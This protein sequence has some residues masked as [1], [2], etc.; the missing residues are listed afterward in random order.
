MAF[1]SKPRPNS[2]SAFANL[3]SETLLRRLEPRIMFD[4]A[5]L[6]TAMDALHAD[7]AHVDVADAA[8]ADLLL[9]LAS[10]S[11]LHGSDLVGLVDHLDGPVAVQSLPN[12]R[13]VVFIDANVPDLAVL[14]AAI[15]DTSEIVVL[16]L[17]KDGLDQMASY[18]ADRHDLDAIH[19]ISHGEPGKLHLGSSTY[20][21]ATL[22]AFDAELGRIGAALHQ[23]GDILIYGCDVAK[24]AEGDAFLHKFADLTHA[25]VAGSTDLTGAA[26]FGGNWVLE[27]K[28]GIIEATAIAAADWTGE[29]N[30]V[31]SVAA[32]NTAVSSIF[33]TQFVGPGITATAQTQIGAAEQFGTFTND[34]TGLGLSK[35]PLSSGIVMVTG[36]ASSAATAAGN[37]SDHQIFDGGVSTTVNAG[38]TSASDADLNA[39]SGNAGIYDAAGFSFKFKSATDR[40]GF[41][42]SFASEEYP[43]FVGTIYNDAFGFFIQGGTDYATKT[44]L[45][46]V[47]GTSEGIAVNT[48]NPGV[49]GS[50]APFAPLATIDA[51]NTGLYI[52]NS[53]YSGDHTVGPY[54]EYDGL[55]KLLTVTAHVTRDT[56]YTMKIAIGDAGDGSYDSA[57]FFKPQGFL[58]LASATA[59]S[60]TGDL[61]HAVSGNVVSDDTGKGVDI[62]PT[63]GGITGITVTQVNGAAFGASPV[64]LASG[65]KVTMHADGSFDY[66]PSTNTAAQALSAGA[67]LNDSFTYSIVDSTGVTDTATVTVKITNPDHAPV[68]VNDTFSTSAGA[69]ITIH[70]LGN[71]SDIDA[72]DTLTVTKVAGQ[73][74]VAG[75]VAI[76]VTGGK[77]TLDSNNDLTFTPNAGYLGSPSFTY[78]INDGHG[79]SA[80]AT[81]GGTVIAAPLTAAADSFT[82]PH[83][84]SILL[85]PLANDTNPSGFAFAITK[86]DGGSITAGGP[87]VTVSG[88]TVAL[89]LT[90]HL[91]FKPTPGYIGTPSF[92]YTIKDLINGASSTATISGAVT[93]AQPLIDLGG[94]TLPSASNL[95]F[96]GGIESGA[97]GW[98]NTSILGLPVPLSYLSGINSPLTSGPAPASSL[99]A[100]NVLTGIAGTI[101]NGHVLLQNTTAVTLTQGQLYNFAFDVKTLVDIQPL[102]P[103]FNWVVLDASNNV[104]MAVPGTFTTGGTGGDLTVTSLAWNT[105]QTLQSSFVSTLATGTYKIGMTWAPALGTVGQTLALD[106]DRIYLGA[107][108]T[109]NVTTFTEDGPAVAIVAGAAQIFDADNATMASAT[110]VLTNKLA[111][112][113]L[114]IGGTAVASGSTGSINGIAYSVLDS[115]GQETIQLT[116]QA[117]KA[118]YAAALHAIAFS[119]STVTPAATDRILN[120]SVNDGM[121]DSAVGVST[122]HVIALPVTAAD[123]G[124][125]IVHSPVTVAVLANDTDAGGTLD[126]ASVKIAGTASAGASLL[127]AGEGTW[128]VNTTSGAITFTPLAAFSSAPTPISYT[129]ADVSGAVSNLASVSIMALHAA[130]HIDLSGQS[131]KDG[132]FTYPHN[133]GYGANP[134][135]ASPVG[136]TTFASVSPETAGPGL[137]L[138]NDGSSGHITQVSS[139]SLATSIAQ[140]EYI[141]MS[142]ATLTTMPETWLQETALRFASGQFQFAMAISSDGFKSA[143]LL[144]TD[145][146]ANTYVGPYYDSNTNYSLTPA[147]DFKLQPGT[148]YELRAYIFN[149]P[150]GAAAQ[151]TWDDFY[152]LYSSDPTGYETTFNAG[153]SPVSISAPAIELEDSNTANMVSASIVLANKQTSDHFAIGGVHTVN[154]STGTIGGINYAVTES[155]GTI[156]VALSGSA[157]EAQ[158]AAFINGVAFENTSSTPAIVDRTINVTVS[159]GVETSNVATTIVHVNVAPEIAVSLGSTSGLDGNSVSIQTKGAFSDANG[160]ALTY[161]AAGLPS[162]LAIDPATGKISGTLP[163]DAS[164]GGIA[165]DGVFAIA[166]TATDP[167]GLAVTNTL[168]FSAN[169]IAPVAS[170][171]AA[172][173]F[174]DAAVTFD[175]LGNDHDGSLDADPLAVSAIDG[176]AIVAGGTAIAV[177][178]GSVLLGLDDKLTFTPDADFNGSASFG[179][180]V[181][182]GQGGTAKAVV[183][184]TVASVNDA[185]AGADSAVST[186]EDADYILSAPD[187]GFTDPSDSPASTFAAVKIATLPGSGALTLNGQAVAQGQTVPLA[188]ITAG[189]LVWTPAADANGAGL[190]SLTFQVQDNGGALNGGLDTDASPN[191]LTFDVTP[192]NDPPVLNLDPDNSQGGADNG[193][194]NASHAVGSA[195]VPI[196]D[197]DV[198]ISDMDSAA[199][200]SLTIGVSGVADG[201]AEHLYVGGASGVDIA[202]DGATVQSGTVTVGGTT[203]LVCFDPLGGTKGIVVTN[204][205]GGAISIA[206]TQALI[207]A[208]T[209]QDTSA[210]STEGPRQIVLTVNDGVDVSSSVAAIID[211]HGGVT[212]PEDTA[213]PLGLNP[214]DFAAVISG[215]VTIQGVPAG[216]TLSSSTL[217]ADGSWTAPVADLASITLTPP[218]DYTGNFSID[219]CGDATGSGG[220]VVITTT[221]SKMAH[222]VTATEVCRTLDIVVIPTPD[223][224]EDPIA[225]NED[226]QA[227]AVN[228]L[229]NDDLGAGTDG[230]D[231][232]TI[233]TAPPA[234]QGVLTFVQDGTGKLTTVA[235]GATLSATE[236]LTLTFKPYLNYNGTVTIP[237]I[238]TDVNGATSGANII[239][240]VQAVD[241]P[242]QVVNPNDPHTN[243]QDPSYGPADPNAPGY[244]PQNPTGVPDPLNLI[245]DV[246]ST[247]GATPASIPA[248]SYFGDAEGDTLTFSATGLPPG[249]SINSTTGLIDGT[250]DSNASQSNTPGDPVGVYTVVVTATDPS[251]HA[252]STT[253]TYT[254]GNLPPVATADTADVSE[255]G[256]AIAGNALANDHDTAL[257][258][259]ALYVAS[260]N[261]DVSLI[262][263]PVAGSTGGSF[264]LKAD[265]TWTFDAGH[266]FDNLAAGQ[267]R[268]T[269]ITYRVAD[270]QGGHA[271]ATVTVTVTGV[272]DAPVALGPIAPVLAVDAGPVTPIDASVAFDNPGNL[273]L[274]YS[275]SNL[276]AGLSIDPATGLITG[277][278]AHGAS[279]QGPYVVM[280]TASGPSGETS[281]TALQINVANPAPVAVA[282][283]ATT[284]A[285]T[286]VT[287]A[288]LANDADADGDTLHVSSI[289]APANGMATLNPDGTITY[290]PNAG[291]VG[292]E[293]ISYT[294]TDAQGGT[295]TA[296]ITIVVGVAPVDAPVATSPIPD[297]PD[298]DGSPIA[299]VDISAFFADPNGQPLAFSATGLPMGL[300]IDPVTGVISGAPASDASV[301]GPYSVVVTAV[302]PDGNQVS[303]TVLFALANPA[304]VAMIDYSATPLDMPVTIH[305]LAN[306]SDPDGDGL[307]VVAV[308]QP[309][310]GTVVINAD[311]TLT[312]TPNA[313]FSGVE[314]FTYTVSDGQRGTSVADAVVAVDYWQPIQPVV[315]GSVPT[316]GSGLDG[317]PIAPIDV[318]SHVTDLFGAPLTFTAAGLPAGLAI[319]ATTGVITG[320]LGANASADGP[321]TVTVIAVDGYGVQVTIPVVITAANPA[322]AAADDVASTAVNQPV[323]IG[324]LA[325]DADP[326][327]DVLTVTATSTPAHGTVAI[328]PNGAV[329]FTP[330]AGFTGT[331]T[332]TYSVT[333]ANGASKTATVTV[334]IGNP[335]SLAAAPGIAAVSGVDGAPIT[336]VSVTAAFGDPDKS[337]LLK[338]SVEETALPPGITFSPLTG[339]FSGT[340]ANNASQGNTLGQPIGTYLVPVTAKDSSSASATTYVTFMFTNQP[341]VA[342]DDKPTVSEDGP[343]LTGNVLGND[344]DTAPDSDPLTV[345]GAAQGANTITLGAP[346][347]TAGGGVLTLKADG[348]YAFNPGTAYNGLPVN[349]TATETI[350]YTV[351]DGNGGATMAKLVITI[352]G[353]N[354]APLIVDPSTG[355]PIGAGQPVIPMQHGVDGEPIQPVAAAGFFR[356]PDAGDVLTY[357]VVNLPKGLHFDPAT[358]LISGVLNTHASVGGPFT[359]EVTATDNHGGNSTATFVWA[360][361]NP[362]PVAVGEI[363][364]TTNG[365]ALHSSVAG[366]DVDPDT[367]GISY[368]VE[369]G[370][371]HG[372]L[373]LHPDGTY[374]YVADSQFSGPDS[375]TY[376]VVDADGGVAYAVCKITVDPA[377]NIAQQTG[378][379]AGHNGGHAEHPIDAPVHPDADDVHEYVLT[380][381]RADGTETLS[382][383]GAEHIRLVVEGRVQQLDQAYGASKRD[384]PLH[385]N[386]GLGRDGGQSGGT[387]YE[388]LGDA[389]FWNGL[390]P[391]DFSGLAVREA[392]V[393][394]ADAPF[395]AAADADHAVPFGDRLAQ[396]RGRFDREALRLMADLENAA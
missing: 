166:V 49:P 141:S 60:Y 177:S 66:D 229:A 221:L 308:T 330:H 347:I 132:A 206:D 267:S 334:N 328:N 247:D 169:N 113:Q 329:T 374:T 76:T 92:T 258:G 218:K 57:V 393:G 367:D 209:Y 124:A 266:A 30:T 366:N 200:A 289:D 25:D 117:N 104:A 88:G 28:T 81:V 369:T 320:A 207:A 365:V 250:L 368:R 220:G 385:W 171:D 362:L 192:V 86:I 34:A 202:L 392:D 350:T 285:D 345:V 21:A 185:P 68:A 118:S 346:F 20:D 261:G 27:D 383:G 193:G 274:V 353:A 38:H 307:A 1:D 122:V 291:F 387:V 372:V 298:T 306:D 16:D 314:Y 148:N 322:P 133:G 332:F 318:G 340:P 3:M 235:D 164:V 130:P 51:N 41:V 12:A 79:G 33:Q 54:L 305:V 121:L 230:V 189:K 67:T 244:D 284:P 102:A 52:S 253:V 142:F 181:A 5:A 105:W 325:N 175:V 282:D 180:T 279:V 61:T 326:D 112:D 95:L 388:P 356:D 277:T 292:T 114:S 254:I 96:N 11:A 295:S 278:P 127:V 90:G 255:D 240:T 154:G 134:S 269:V 156:S 203:F 343:K 373:T 271:I 155:A 378:G 337:G 270:G 9:D 256:P 260:V 172:S 225:M 13:T 315:D 116:G 213:I 336:P 8:P 58:A 376:A 341:P 182:D 23:G 19:I 299:P 272:N 146:T 39:L 215:E 211:V 4:A 176:H 77:V 31:I 290:V 24:G 243:P 382:D 109:R 246:A 259:D 354:D 135:W 14:E 331:D 338:L 178:H 201:A 359:V 97:S 126:P 191:T 323:V 162:W 184:V 55:T 395:V 82:T 311:G 381:A 7:P 309:A 375:F 35:I 158:Y 257:D 242:V 140:G 42:F 22:K 335:G 72:G 342:L 212:G 396:I 188:D 310:N 145:K 47:P 131:P 300:I 139:T 339:T 187:F 317:S 333:D 46:V 380:A 223:A 144:S 237:Y 157:S 227:I 74:I 377:I 228:P 238:M 197:A 210:T 71:D 281:S 17:A 302:D 349:A 301:S 138:T 64:T 195:P 263:Q 214:A 344:H 37:T 2:V 280:V 48:I 167:K 143:T 226:D 321:F 371:S 352:N 297:Q 151:G 94:P 245:P 147:A 120:V 85:S 53:L 234:T 70:V 65:A 208:S 129:V 265:G 199:M 394:T 69:P 304:P 196:S 80:T 89:D 249:L 390:N 119:N 204:L 45:A 364:R 165:G 43:E 32:S 93:D 100:I 50:A 18:L 251:G 379:G 6:E 101:G 44:N 233:V 296:A 29:L 324:V 319:D 363:A 357:S 163:S 236:A 239:V 198:L 268:D 149:M 286:P 231:D 75:G 15:A 216:A 186:P 103:N 316:S 386:L 348:S 276:P 56:Q 219:V 288:P 194:I 303:T 361:D 252:A 108:P 99:G 351:S 370:P 273:P 83:D 87:A 222:A 59:N 161:S 123:S 313:G 264:V 190:A 106:L 283:N 173:T 391:L 262:G 160:D 358:G 217:N 136:L 111:G 10:T 91:L 232:L 312:Y 384:V 84:T 360:I 248:G 78:T 168:T 107:E 115:A 159:D 62:T 63:S 137:T 224:V 183:T 170:N 174:E 287:I 153:G 294:I 26:Q 275:A 327:H 179:Y 125:G 98:A 150:G 205:A 293:T 73:A 110:V 389:P 152:A 355:Q 241:D 36:Q 128:S 40:I